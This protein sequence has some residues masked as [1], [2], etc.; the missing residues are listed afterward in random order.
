MEHEKT[1]EELE[2]ARLNS[3]VEKIEAEKQIL[4]DE[5]DAIENYMHTLIHDFKTPLSSISGFA[6][7]LVEDEYSKEDREEFG[8]IIIDTTARMFKMIESYLLLNKFEKLGGK[9]DKKTKTVLEIIDGIKKIFNKKYSDNELRIFSK[10]S[11]DSSVDFEL[12]KKEIEFDPDLFYSAVTNLIN[13]AIESSGQAVVNIFSEDNFFCINVFNQGV[14]PE[15]TEKK[16]F[17][18]FN[19]TKSSGTGL[20]LF[21]S[22]LIAQAHGG[23]L[24]YRSLPGGTLFTLSIPFK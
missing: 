11:E 13:N 7:L 10:K 12:F 21:S 5:K 8:R 15:E 9:L 18:K 17:Q 2:I 4:K 19:T 3:I 23:D 14:I 6:E 22:K 24:V 20:G 1:P 16:L